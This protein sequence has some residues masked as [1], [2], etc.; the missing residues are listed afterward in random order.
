MRTQSVRNLPGGNATPRPV[1]LRFIQISLTSLEIFIQFFW[2]FRSI[3]E[4]S[5]INGVPI[6]PIKPHALLASLL[7]AVCWVRRDVKR[8]YPRRCTIHLDRVVLT[9]FFLDIYAHKDMR[10]TSGSAR[11]E[12][13]IHA[14][15]T[16]RSKTFEHILLCVLFVHVS[17]IMG[18]CSINRNLCSKYRNS[19]H[20]RR[21]CGIW[22]VA[23]SWNL[24]SR[25]GTD[26]I[27]AWEGMILIPQQRFEISLE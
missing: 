16:W 15:E 12:L 5:D 14:S 22:V 25:A 11:I 24:S 9:S 13:F 19:G 20:N 18:Q 2:M 6:V 8:S 23:F 26:V 4:V 3:Y 7:I 21:D 27:F 1:I 17:A 10:Y